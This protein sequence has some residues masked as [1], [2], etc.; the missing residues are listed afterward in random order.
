MGLNWSTEG[1]GL[2]DHLSLRQWHARSLLAAI[3]KRYGIISK[4]NML[5]LINQGALGE[6]ALCHCC[7]KIQILA[8]VSW[9]IVKPAASELGSTYE[10]WLGPPCC[11]KSFMHNMGEHWLLPGD[12]FGRK[13]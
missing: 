3:R 10:A 8:T 7:C 9:F 13:G 1:R 11:L 12:H 2:F 4:C 5:P 6:N